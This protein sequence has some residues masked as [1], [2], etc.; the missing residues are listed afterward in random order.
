MK[1]WILKKLLKNYGE[2]SGGDIQRSGQPGRFGLWLHYKLRPFKSVINLAYSPE[3]DSQDN[4]EE[5]FCH[6]RQIEYVP[7]AFS[8][9]GP[10]TTEGID[11]RHIAELVLGHIDRLAKPVWV[12]CEGGK[13]RT[14]GIVMRWMKKQG[15]YTLEEIVGQ[16]EK[17]K[18]PADGWLRWAIMEESNG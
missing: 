3:T 7:F 6:D 16:C 18:T 5:S 15:S 10:H 12:H 14:G 9:G 1:K 11:A 13:D 17:H 2:I 8:A 4:H